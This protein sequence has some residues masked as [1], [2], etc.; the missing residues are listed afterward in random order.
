[1]RP[2]ENPG[3]PT[4]GQRIHHQEVGDSWPSVPP[5]AADIAELMADMPKPGTP[6]VERAAWLSRKRAMLFAITAAKR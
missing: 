2:N 1:M 6:A 3:A 4:P 5:K